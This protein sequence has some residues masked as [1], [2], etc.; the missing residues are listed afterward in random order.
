[1]RKAGKKWEQL[2]EA[3]IHFSRSLA[4]SVKTEPSMCTIKENLWKKSN[5]NLTGNIPIMI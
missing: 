5:L 2:N 1:M 3:D 4:L